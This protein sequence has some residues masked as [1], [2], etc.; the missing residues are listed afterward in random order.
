MLGFLNKTDKK[1]SDYKPTMN[2]SNDEQPISGLDKHLEL[3]TKYMGFDASH[4]DALKSARPVILEV[5]DELLEKVLDHLF[6]FPPLAEIATT[7]TTRERL[8]HVF[9]NYFKSLFSGE[10]DDSYLQMR[11]RI[12]GTHNSNGL[13]ID[14]FLATYSAIQSLLVPKIVEALKDDPEKLTKTL[15]AIN[16]VVNFDSQLVVNN[17]MDSKIAEIDEYNL[18]NKQ[19]QQELTAI[20]QELAASVEET[21]ASINETTSRAEQIRTET[22]NTQKSSHNLVNLTSQN[23]SEMEQMIH[24]FQDVAVRVTHS[25]ERTEK[26]RTISEE[27]TK[28][29]NEIVNIADQTNLLALNA[30]I[31]AARAGDE[32]KGFAVVAEEVRKLAENSKEMSNQIVSLISDSNLNIETLV[33]EMGEMNT[34]TNSSQQQINQ[35]KSGLSTVKMEME[36]YLDMFGRNKVDLDKIVDSI[37]E[38]NATTQ[39]LTSLSSQLIEKAETLR[40]RD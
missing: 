30:S 20:S 3:K 14:W 40:G 11:Q 33:S 21:D 39:G 26:L 27:I 13:P 32:G 8:K 34:S 15:L 17:Y 7:K 18:K 12:G 36:N 38:I 16:H 9:V 10:I 37:Q 23:E 25:I 1:I 24:S 6:Q 31:E 22:E 5:L 29:T 19:L 28:M 35:V 4:L 2:Y